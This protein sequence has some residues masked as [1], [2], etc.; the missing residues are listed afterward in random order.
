M[1]SMFL[2]PLF[3]L[4]VI[5]PGLVPH[6]FCGATAGFTATLPADVAGG[7]RGFAHGLLISFL[8]AILLPM[9]GDM[10]LGS[11]TFGDADFGVVGIVLGH[12]IAMFN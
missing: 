7:G 4:S 11:T 8:P 6:F 9:M 5:V 10:G 12:I 2:C 1:V 3:G